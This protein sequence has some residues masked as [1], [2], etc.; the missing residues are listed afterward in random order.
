MVLDLFNLE[1]D[2]QYLESLKHEHE[3]ELLEAVKAGK[4]RTAE[5]ILR[6]ALSVN[7]KLQVYYRIFDSI[8]ESKK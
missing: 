4:L 3:T 5:Q 1:S 7:D 2:I 8:L 6:N